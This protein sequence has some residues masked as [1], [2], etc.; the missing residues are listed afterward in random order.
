M[1]VI[2]NILYIEFA[3]LV[4]CGVN[5]YTIKAAKVRQSNGWNFIKDPRDKR[6]VLIEYSEL[7]DAYKD[8]INTRFGNPY[9]YV[10]KQPIK[11]NP[12]YSKIK[13]YRVGNSYPTIIKISKIGFSPMLLLEWLS[14]H[15]KVG[16]HK[17]YKCDD[18][19]TLELMLLCA[20]PKEVN[21]LIN[22]INANLPE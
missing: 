8:K 19:D 11:E 16:I 14:E 3:E 9:D 2:D 12:E 5:P 13:A 7:K 22:Y 10:A 6:K 21:D 4:S 18:N 17:V 1:K 15:P 20:I